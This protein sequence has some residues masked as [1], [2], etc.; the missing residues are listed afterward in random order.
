MNQSQPKHITVHKL[1]SMFKEWEKRTGAD[2]PMIELF[3]D[4]SGI[5]CERDLHGQEHR[6]DTIEELV[7]ILEG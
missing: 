2:S 6:F 4:G 1:I 3:P 5:F 7:E